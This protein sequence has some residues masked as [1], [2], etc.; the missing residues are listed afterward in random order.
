MSRSF[1]IEDAKAVS[2]LV[3]RTLRETNIKDYSKEYIQNDISKMDENFFI[4]RGK[5][6]NCYVFLDENTESIIGIGSIGSYWG[7]ETES[8]LFTIFV[9]PDYQGKGIGKQI[10]EKLESDEYFLRADR[11]EIPASIT[12]LS[13]YQKMGYDF[14]NGVDYID[15]EGLYR[16]EKFTF[17]E[18]D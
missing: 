16:L 12:A 9:S 7:S 10:M 1:K 14:K 2:E 5:W 8:S 15:E 11:I 13:F 17:S 3:R 4:E 6:T 18:T